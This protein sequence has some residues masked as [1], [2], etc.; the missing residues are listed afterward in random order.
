[1]VEIP[2]AWFG[3]YTED[4]GDLAGLEH[5]ELGLKTKL[6]GIEEKLAKARG[7]GAAAMLHDPLGFID[8]YIRFPP[9][10]GLAPYQREIIA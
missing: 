1:M 4:A 10:A 9:G 5:I 7:K 6:L 3:G 2:D 8:T